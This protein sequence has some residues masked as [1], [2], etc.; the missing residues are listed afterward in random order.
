MSNSEDT[1]K[2]IKSKGDNDPYK[3]RGDLQAMI[4]DAVTDV[5]TRLVLPRLTALEADVGELKTDMAAMKTDIREIKESLRRL[6][7]RFNNFQLE[8]LERITALED[9]VG[10]APKPAA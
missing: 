6:E 3:T 8:T 7:R 4:I 1:T 2:D 5:V 9:R 10:D